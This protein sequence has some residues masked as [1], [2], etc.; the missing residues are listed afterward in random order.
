MAMYLI[1]AGIQIHHINGDHWVASSSIGRG[2]A[3]VQQQLHNGHLR[4][5][6]K[7]QLALIYRTLIKQEEGGEQV[8]PHLK[9]HV[10]AI[11][12]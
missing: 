12:Q 9:I 3:G 1:H 7:N 2:S 10:P 6:I 8:D 11:E 4:C 5:S